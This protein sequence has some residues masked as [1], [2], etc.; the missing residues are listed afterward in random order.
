MN[1]NDTVSDKFEEY[2]NAFDLD[3]LPVRIDID[4][5]RNVR[6]IQS[7]NNNNITIVQ[8]DLRTNRYISLYIPGYSKVVTYNVG[9]LKWSEW[10]NI[11]FTVDN[12]L[13]YN[14][15]GEN[16]Q[17]QKDYRKWVE[18]NGWVN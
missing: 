1:N 15:S 5:K 16:I 9:K 6:Y 2:N 14:E 12:S 18:I 3:G 4:K 7:V 8:H 17:M 13:D 10:E 11:W